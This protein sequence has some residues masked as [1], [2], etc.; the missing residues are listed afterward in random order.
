MFAAVAKFARNLIKMFSRYLNLN[1]EI[2]INLMEKRHA[3]HHV[4][5]AP[6][7]FAGPF[8]LQSWKFLEISF[9]RF[10]VTG[11]ENS[12]QRRHRVMMVVM[13]TWRVPPGALNPFHRIA[14]PPEPRRGM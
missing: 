3:L 13:G 9:L 5:R 6:P 7:P 4:L 12:C 11:I 10:Y 8:F 1:F 2:P 14:V